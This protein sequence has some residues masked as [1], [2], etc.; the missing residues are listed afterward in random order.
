MY[1]TLFTPEEIEKQV[2]AM[3]LCFYLRLPIIFAKLFQKNILRDI[4]KYIKALFDMI[5]N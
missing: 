4:G 1:G 3:Y 2:K 5:Y